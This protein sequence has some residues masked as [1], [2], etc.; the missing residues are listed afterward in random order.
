M[1]TPSTNPALTGKIVPTFFYYVLP[2]IVGL[3]ALTTANLVDGIVVGNYVGS[4]SLASITILIPYFTLMFGIGLMLSIGGS[5]RAGRYIGENKLDAASSIY[6]KSMITIVIFSILCAILSGF[7]ETH[8]FTMLGAPLELFP[9]LHE[10]FSIIRWAL[11]IQLIGMVFYYFVRLDGHPYLATI[12]LVSGAILNIVLDIIF[13]GYMSQGLSGAAYA[14]AI[15]QLIQIGILSCYLLSDKFSSHQRKLRFSLR[16]TQWKE[17]ISTAY[18]GLSEFINEISAGVILLLLNWLL[19][20]RYGVD[21]VAAFTIINYLIFLSLMLSYGVAD[22]LHLVI[23]Q[24]LGAQQPIR[25]RH[26]L[27]TAVTTVLFIGIVLVI[28]LLSFNQHI[29]TVFLDK[30]SLPVAS[31]ATQITLIIWPLFLVNGINVILS[32]YLTAIHKPLP[33]TI[34]AASRSL[35]LPGSLL[36]LFFWLIPTLQ[37]TIDITEDN[38]FL[39][40]LPIAEWCTFLLAVILAFYNRPSRLKHE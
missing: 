17:I 28:I 19:I 36:L 38:N 40:A 27:I 6:S 1:S 10:Y 18:N 15:A 14:T 33:S 22:G 13:V 37:P 39:I 30:N 35:V 11:V 4:N 29:I 12:A 7:V 23:S 31:L 26:F 32:C 2:S 9:L 25:I 21:G 16:Q 3:V 5:V 24:N 34:I 20:S 8:I